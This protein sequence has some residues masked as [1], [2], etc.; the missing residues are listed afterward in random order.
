LKGMVG[1]RL[2]GP[3]D[4]ARIVAVAARTDGATHFPWESS[5]SQSDRESHASGRWRY[6]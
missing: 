5:P 3:H 6:G 1:C 4:L 2:A